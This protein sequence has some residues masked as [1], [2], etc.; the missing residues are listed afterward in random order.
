MKYYPRKCPLG[1]VTKA[2][3]IVAHDT[4]NLPITFSYLFRFIGNMQKA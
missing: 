2:K 4:V 1:H 3:L